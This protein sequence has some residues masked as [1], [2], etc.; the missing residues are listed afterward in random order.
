MAFDVY[1]VGGNSGFSEESAIDSAKDRDVAAL[2][3]RMAD[4]VVDPF[5][6]TNTDFGITTSGSSLD[7]DVDPGSAFM[8]GH[9]V[10]SDATVTLTLDASTT[11][12]IW[13]VVRD[14]A[15]G[16][17]IIE[18]NTTGS[19][20]S[21]LYAI[22]LWRVSTDS[23]GVTGTTDRRPYTPFRDGATTQDS[24]T[25]RKFGE[26]GT[27]AVDSTGVKTV[28]V[29]FTEPYRTALDTVGLE[30]NQLDDTAVVFGFVRAIN[31]TPSGFDIQVRVD[32]AGASGSQA[33]FDWET[34]GK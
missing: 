20:P 30:L 10:V 3:G 26:S 27:V 21:G 16:N 32:K 18:Y 13:L 15:T 11:N 7:V 17:A 29:S 19:A 2:G 33:T 1:P 24:V 12:Y 5:D 6:G 31:R 23:S 9:K 34:Q 28:S 25:G 4:F 22:E 14:A 8:S